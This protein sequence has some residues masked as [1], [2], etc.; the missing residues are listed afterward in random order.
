MAFMCELCAKKPTSGNN[1]SHAN[2]RTRRVFNPNLQT[3]RAIVGG[4]HSASA[5]AP[6]ACDQGWSRKRSD[7]SSPFSRHIGRTPSPY[8][9]GNGLG[10]RGSARHFTFHVFM[11][12]IR[13][14]NVLL[15]TFNVSRLRDSPLVR[16]PRKGRTSLEIPCRGFKRAEIAVTGISRLPFHVSRLAW[17]L[18]RAMGFEPTTTSLGS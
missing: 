17:G 15:F 9:R 16:S 14:R 3:V 6:A 8:H 5:Y 7:L 18:E 11:V 13:R 12:S 10:V 1:V 2:N 4:A